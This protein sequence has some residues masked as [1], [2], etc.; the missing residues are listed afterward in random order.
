MTPAGKIATMI[1]ALVGIPLM[2]MILTDLGKLLTRIMKLPWFITK[3]V[4]RRMCRC[5]FR[6]SMEQIVRA[7]QRDRQGLE[8]VLFILSAL[9]VFFSGVRPTNT[10][11]NRHRNRLDIRMLS[12]SNDL[13]APVGLPCRILLLLHLAHN[14]WCA[15][16]SVMFSAYKRL[17][18]SAML[19]PTIHIIYCSPSAIFS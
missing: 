12:D 2:L 14:D 6:L 9:K 8:V 18:D 15:L 16:I 5:C 13:G 1:Y 7:E 19:C 10:S 3:L 4:V 17:Q 11:G